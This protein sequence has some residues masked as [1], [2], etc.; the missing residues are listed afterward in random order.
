MLPH[1]LLL[2]AGRAT[3]FGGQKLLALWRGRPLVT[4]SIALIGALRARGR[5]AGATAVTPAGDEAV[6]PLLR[7][8]GFRI[9]RNDHPE[10]GISHSL[11][12]GL[13]SLAALEPQPEAALIFLADQPAAPR[14]AAEEVIGAWQAGGSVVVRPRYADTPDVPGHPLLLDRDAWGIADSLRG[15]QGLGPALE[16]SPHLVLQVDVDGANPDVDVPADLARIERF[17]T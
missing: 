12:L 13:G 16:R 14:E 8:G 7:Q 11:R 15:D 17:P 9:V 2:A 6:T 4:H 5:L 3:R 1:A 10:W